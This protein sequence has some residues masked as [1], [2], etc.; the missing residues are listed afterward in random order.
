MILTSGDEKCLKQRGHS[1]IKTL[2]LVEDWNA[3]SL[4]EDWVVT[5]VAE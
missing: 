3:F 1:K 5:S 2:S 4:A